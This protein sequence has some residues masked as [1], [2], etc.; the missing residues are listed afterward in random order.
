MHCNIGKFDICFVFL[1]D[2]FNS[3]SPEQYGHYFTD[4]IF[5]CLFFNEKFCIL[6][7]ISLMF[8]LKGPIDSNLSLI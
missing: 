3:F 4:G 1:N 2:V 7:K 5:R 8:V 6:I